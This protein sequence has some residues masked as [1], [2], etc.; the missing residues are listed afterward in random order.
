MLTR[1]K[2]LL[3]HEE[4]LLLALSDK[5]GTIESG[6]W[7][8][9]AIAGAILSE[10]LLAKRITMSSDKK[11][12]VEIIDASSYGDEIIDEALNRISTAKRRAN[13]QT[14]VQRLSALK[15]LKHRVANRLCKKGVLRSDEKS[16]LLIFKQKVYP[17]LD[18]RP[19]RR[20]VER[21][22]QA[23]FSDSQSVDPRTVVLVSLASASDMLKIPFDHKKLKG[24]KKRIEMLINGDLMGRA[25]KEAVQA[26]QTAIM[27]ACIMPAMM[28]V[29]IS[30]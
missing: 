9:Q 17:E 19:E 21:L 18:P 15:Q 22:E 8:Q 29:F 11:K 14:W 26:A 24:R 20:L 3:L 25:T 12:F 16:I 6:A 4:I 1:N 13:L 10:L 28:P 30:S 23:I 7:Y 5:K 27:V 2:S